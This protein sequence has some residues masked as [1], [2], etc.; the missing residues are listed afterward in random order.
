M[1]SLFD[2]TEG[3]ENIG[4]IYDRME[5]NCPHPR[6]TSQKLWALRH[7]CDIPSRSRNQ[8]CETLIEKAVANL[9]ARG[10][11]PGWFNQCPTASGI[12]DSSEDRRTASRRGKRRDVDLVHWCGS[13]KHAR[14]VELK[15]ASDDPCSALKQILRYG[16]TY[17]FCRI[18]K[19]E[20]PLQAQPLM[21][22]AHVS[23]EVVAPARYYLDSSQKDCLV[24]MRDSLNRFVGSKTGG[25]WSMS[26]NVL[27]FPEDFDR[28]P[29]TDGEDVIKK[30]RGASA[31]GQKVCAAF[32]NLASVWPAP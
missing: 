22:A 2:G 27:A 8:S 9:A 1:A 20:L 17:I 21:D 7:A 12:A 10:H 29:F 5:A 30:C 15:W 32:N 3:M 26:L 16:A 14:L 13:R 23:L 31:E 18:H 24:R 4:D 28:V 6:S 11:M 25:I 19:K